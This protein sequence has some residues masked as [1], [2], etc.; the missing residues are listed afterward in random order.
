M[1]NVTLD[2]SAV[3]YTDLSL[4]TSYPSVSS[5]RT[6]PVGTAHSRIICSPAQCCAPIPH[7]AASAR[8]RK[9]SGS[10]LAR[11]SLAGA[12]GIAAA[13][14]A[15]VMGYAMPVGK[16]SPCAS[17][18]VRNAC[19]RRRGL[20]PKFV[21]LR[22]HAEMLWQRAAEASNV[23]TDRLEAWQCLDAAAARA[24]TDAG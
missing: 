23:I 11:R 10:R 20:T 3:L 21:A 15:R 9:S 4:S 17:L 14:A 6:D 18:S 7:R 13:A 16:S 1:L 19:R 5:A 12:C 2:L 22:S 8:T 24:Q